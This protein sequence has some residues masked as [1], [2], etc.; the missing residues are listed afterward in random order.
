MVAA[1]SYY[2]GVGGG[3]QSFIKAIQYD[4]LFDVNHAH[5]TT[6]DVTH[7]VTGQ[8]TLSASS[9]LHEL[10]ACLFLTLTNA[11][12]HKLWTLRVQPASNCKGLSPTCAAGLLSA[13]ANRKNGKPIC[14][15][16][17]AFWH[18]ELHILDV[19]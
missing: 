18:T 12:V 11:Q 1:K 5:K 17:A 19:L 2:F 10:L 3:V 13:Y 9:S 16:L 7:M 6:E 4:N 15:P 8:V 14:C